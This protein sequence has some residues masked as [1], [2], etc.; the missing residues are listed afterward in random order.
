VELP[1]GTSLSLS[2]RDLCGC[3]DIYCRLL[4]CSI[5]CSHVGLYYSQFAVSS[6]HEQLD[7]SSIAQPYYNSSTVPSS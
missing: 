2:W 5:T 4:V 1:L 3:V 6:F 7:Y